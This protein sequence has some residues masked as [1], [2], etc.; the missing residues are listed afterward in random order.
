[1]N[2]IVYLLKLCKLRDYKRIFQ[3][4]NYEKSV[5]MELTLIYTQ[6]NEVKIK[7]NRQV[8]LPIQIFQSIGQGYSLSPLFCNLIKK[9]KIIKRRSL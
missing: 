7:H 8:F 5:I 3:A 2:I 4:Y 9:R 1:M 6:T